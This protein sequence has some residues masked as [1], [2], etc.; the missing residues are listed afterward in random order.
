MI[1]LGGKS[2]LLTAAVDVSLQFC[3]RAPGQRTTS[4]VVQAGRLG[5]GYRRRQGAANMGEQSLPS[6]L[7]RATVTAV[8][9]TDNLTAHVWVRPE[10]APEDSEPMPVS[11][12]R[13]PDHLDS[14]VLEVVEGLEPDDTVE[15]G[16]TQIAEGE[17]TINLGRTIIKT[18]A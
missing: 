7:I 1:D 8:D 14:A 16:Y 5:H 9:L 10:R 11:F 13:T 18:A 6:F 3:F 12:Q 4:V 2:G 17:R 15:V